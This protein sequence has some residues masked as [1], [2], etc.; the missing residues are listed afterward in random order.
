MNPDLDTP[1][2]EIVPPP[3]EPPSPSEEA[4]ATAAEAAALHRKVLKGSVWTLAG[5][6][7][8][9]VIR[10][11]NNL[12]LTRMMLP[13]PIGVMNLANLFMMGLQMFSD[14][15]IRPSI[16]QNKRGDDPDFLNTAWTMSVIRGFMLWFVS[17]ALAWPYA[18]FYGQSSLVWLIPVVG[19]T[20]VLA[21]MNST[22]LVTANRN[23][24]LGRLTL[25]EVTAQIINT[26]VVLAWAYFDPSPWALVAGGMSNGIVYLVLGFVWMPGVKHRFRWEK[27]S[28]K[29][30]IRFGRWVFLSTSI[31]FLAVQCDPIV[32][33]K[34]TT[35]AALAVYGIGKMWGTLPSEVFQQLLQKVFFPVISGM[36][37][38]GDLDRT[39][40]NGLR[41]RLL[42]PVA[43]GTGATFVVAVPAIRILY[44]AEYWDAGP[45][46]GITALGA[47]IGTIAQT[48]VIVL[49]SAGRLKNMTV[50]T[51]TK[52]SLFFALAYPA[53][54]WW[55]LEGIAIAVA[56]AELGAL[57]PLLIG[58]HRLHVAM[59]MRELGLTGI[60]VA[61]GLAM[62]GLQYAAVS[63]SGSSLAGVVAVGVVTS[64][65]CLWCIKVL[66]AHLR[67]A[68]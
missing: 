52:T 16:I 9:R 8:S 24:A 43:I 10:L 64:A 18:A 60:G 38:A 59:P 39:K 36:V 48:Y 54:Q 56:V 67:R 4:A 26:L 1:V 7:A 5:Y 46:F 50:A 68:G 13:G 31:T 14:I 6:A 62:Y 42:L 44:R 17:C 12:V 58:A 65:A 20:A 37:R 35:M 21:G 63:I 57:V 53:F 61:Y 22:A 41:T 51:A 49:L 15:G 34:I 3:V 30:L 27:E 32:L 25:L 11:A 19:Y 29:E 2:P 28:A 40:I 23:L 45:I 66:F 55:N 33:G 47:W